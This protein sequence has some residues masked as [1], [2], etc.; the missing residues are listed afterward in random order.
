MRTPIPSP[1]RLDVVLP[2]WSGAP[3]ADSSDSTSQ[4]VLG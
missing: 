3:H 1:T 4:D 2:F